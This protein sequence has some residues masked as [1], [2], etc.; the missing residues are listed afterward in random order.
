M[1]AVTQMGPMLVLAGMI[2]GWV[3]EGFVRSGGR[4]FLSDLALGLVGSLIVGTVV[5]TLTAGGPGMPGMLGIGAVGGALAIYAQRML[6][7][8]GR[9]G[10]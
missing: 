6:W 10:T 1:E 8:P 9:S 2:A 3:A 4:G 5:W 7:P